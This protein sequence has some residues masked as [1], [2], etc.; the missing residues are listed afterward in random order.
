MMATSTQKTTY[1]P[2]SSVKNV[3]NSQH[4]YIISNRDTSS[5]IINNA[6]SKHQHHQL[7]QI[8]HSNMENINSNQNS[9]TYFPMNRLQSCHSHISQQQINSNYHHVG[10]GSDVSS[11]GGSCIG[12]QLQ[13]QMVNSQDKNDPH[14]TATVHGK[15]LFIT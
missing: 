3:N 1:S 11:V 15:L 6:N 8:H 13:N 14:R 10:I 12:V 4:Q 5:S 7:N 9:N 2:Q